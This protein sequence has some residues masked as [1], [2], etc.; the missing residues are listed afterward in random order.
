[1]LCG[2]MP[3]MANASTNGKTA[4]QATDWARQQVNSPTDFD[5]VYG[6]QCVDLIVGYYRYLGQSSPSGDGCAYA[7]NSLPSG[8]SRI[9]YYGGFVPNPG[10]I[11]VWT[12][13][14][15]AKGHVAIVLS[16]DS[17]GFTVAQFNGSTHTGS[18]QYYSYSY[19]TLYGF[20]R[21]DFNGGGGDNQS[22]NI[23]DDFY[24]FIIKLD[25]WKHLEN[26]ENG[27]IQIAKNGN[28]SSDP[29]QIWHF[30]RQSNNSYKIISE[31]DNKCI[32]AD[33]SKNTNETNIQVWEN[34]DTQNQRWYMISAGNGGY[35]IR[36]A[37]CNLVFDCAGNRNTGGN[38]IQLY[39]CNNSN[40]QIFTIYHLTEDG[41]NYKKP[42]WPSKVSIIS[43]QNNDQR[44][45]IISWTKAPLIGQF[46][47]REYDLRIFDLSDNKVFEK[48]G[49]TTNNYTVTL[50]KCGEYYATIASVNS[51]YYECFTFSDKYYFTKEHSYT[52]AVTK[53]PTCTEKGTRTF[54]CSC[55]NS[56]T[57]P[58]NALGHKFTNYVYNNDAT[59]EHDGTKTAKCDR[60]SATDTITAPGTRLSANQPVIS[61][62][63][64]TETK[65]V[66]YKTTVTFTADTENEV[67]GA[68]I[69]WFINGKDT[70]TGNTYTQVLAKASYNVQLKYIKNG[71]V[72]AESK[73]ETVEVNTSFFAKLIAILRTI[74]NTLPV[75][76]QA[77]KG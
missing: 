30:I 16:A 23:G 69:H 75:V 66:G 17:S 56:Y 58:V 28:N 10:D 53:E 33:H 38:N 26:G 4:A 54:T 50:P 19:G 44:Q 60:C 15:S 11:A 9:A 40:A 31:Y 46:D 62:H 64:Y 67:N 35:Y 13:A 73:I 45:T 6:I 47:K 68:E 2:S 24:A 20:I 32:D 71:T 8:W 41:V 51:Y 42:S 63:N 25:S 12:Y 27:N 1:M 5:G 65:N 52:S 7:S 18:I 21:P 70:A 77:I 14:S 61:I 43:A 39:E 22:V 3:I 74:F 76:S 48:K 57:E 59:I 49:I 37:Y 34:G 36:A 29:R 55:G 72:L